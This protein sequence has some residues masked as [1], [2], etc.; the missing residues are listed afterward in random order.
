M[1]QPEAR[2]ITHLLMDFSTLWQQMTLTESRAILQAMFAALFF[3]AQNQLKKV[4][5]HEQC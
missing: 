3:D 4:A 5:A 1:P 2:Q